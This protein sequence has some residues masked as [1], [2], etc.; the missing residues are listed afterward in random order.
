[1]TN[2]NINQN[3]NN[4]NYQEQMQKLIEERQK[5]QNRIKKLDNEEKK[6]FNSSN[7]STL[8]LRQAQISY[9][10]DPFKYMD[11]LLEQHFKNNLIKD[12]EKIKEKIKEDYEKFEKG[13]IEDFTIFKNRQKVYLEKLQ[14]K[15]YIINRK[16]NNLNFLDEKAELVS[17][18]LY[19]G[20]DIKNIF[21]QFPQYKYNLVINSAG[22]TKNELINDINS[23]L[24]KNKLCHGVIQ[25]MSGGGCHPNYKSPEHKFLEVNNIK[26]NREKYIEGKRNFN[27]K[28]YKEK[29]EKDCEEKIYENELK[30]LNLENKL[31]DEKYNN[32]INKINE[33]EKK[34]NEYFKILSDIKDQ[35]TKDKIFND[36]THK[37][38][39]IFKK[40]EEEIKDIIIIGMK[41]KSN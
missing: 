14:D 27:I 10:K 15:N 2:N 19:Q 34:N 41:K 37:Q 4:L 32:Y 16:K 3:Y 13:L 20:E 25:S 22:D 36:L 17:E 1:M 5:I 6:D 30:T 29:I 8:E 21:N 12:D 24:Y 40:S 26:L 28:R 31:F 33:C 7:N 11:F 35:M 38:L 18:P 23:N 39:N 9:C